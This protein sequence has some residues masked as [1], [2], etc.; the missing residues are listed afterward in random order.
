ML[1]GISHKNI[2]LQ[3][4][5]FWNSKAMSEVQKLCTIKFYLENE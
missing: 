5:I 2:K 4:I 1:V 3:S